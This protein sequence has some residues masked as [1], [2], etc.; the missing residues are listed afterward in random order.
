MP[1][2]WDRLDF[3]FHLMDRLY[4]YTTSDFLVEEGR[5]HLKQK[6]N[7]WC[8]P[9]NYIKLLWVVWFISRHLFSELA[10]IVI[11]YIPYPFVY[12]HEVLFFNI[13]FWVMFNSK[14]PSKSGLFD[15]KMGFYSRKTQKT[16]FLKKVRLYSRVGLYTSGYGIFSSRT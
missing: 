16:G 7:Q 4:G 14:N 15:Q 2:L 13:G 3:L 9:F 10:V 11:F 12:N 5:G 1:F 8:K 6:K